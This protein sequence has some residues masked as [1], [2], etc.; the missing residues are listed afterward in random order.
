MSPKGK[1][2][3]DLDVKRATI[4]VFAKLLRHR[5]DD[6]GM[7]LIPEQSRCLCAGELHEIVVTDRAP[8]AGGRIDV[9]GFLGFAEILRA[10]VVEAGDRVAVAGRE[11]GRVA[12][13]DACHWPNHYNV[14]VHAER[15]LTATDLGLRVGDDLVL[16]AP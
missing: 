15:P 16:R 14:I 6:R 12:G 11:I 3:D 9:V 13:F 7:V 4:A 10:G 1:R 8:D 2:G 5:C